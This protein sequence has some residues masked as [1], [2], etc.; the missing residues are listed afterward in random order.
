MTPAKRLALA[1]GW[2]SALRELTRAALRNQFT[3]ASEDEL[4]RHFAQRWLGP[5]LAAK[6]Y[7]M[8]RWLRLDWV[9]GTVF[10]FLKW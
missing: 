4:K 9:G 8:G 1:T 7:G 6:V 5:E 2:S 3:G 10:Y